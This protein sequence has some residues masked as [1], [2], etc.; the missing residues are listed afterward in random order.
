MYIGQKLETLGRVIASE[1]ERPYAGAAAQI[2]SLER[3]CRKPTKLESRRES[4]GQES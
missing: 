1:M 4:A 2:L 3:K